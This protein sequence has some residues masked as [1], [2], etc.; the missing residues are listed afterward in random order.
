MQWA[1]AEYS[2]EARSFSE[3]Q[4]FDFGKTYVN[5]GY[6]NVDVYRQGGVFNGRC[7]LGHTRRYIFRLT[8]NNYIKARTVAVDVAV[9]QVQATEEWPYTCRATV[10]VPRITGRMTFF[11][12]SGNFCEQILHSPL[13]SASIFLWTLNSHSN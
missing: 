7:N 12:Q 10:H 1:P 4:V 2:P 6:F 9:E 13:T 8:A 5:L 3:D 11:A